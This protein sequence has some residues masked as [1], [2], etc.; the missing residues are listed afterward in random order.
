MQFTKKLRK[1]IVN[2]E[3][4]TTIRI[5]KRS[6]VKIGGRYRL[7]EGAIVVTSITEISLQDISPQLAKDSGF[8]GIVDLLKTA[9][10]GLGQVIYFIRFYY[11]E[12]S[13]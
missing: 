11:E 1:R 5:W 10:H 4:T 13:Y 2:G 6:H 9:K 12:T 7:E 3:I 8:D